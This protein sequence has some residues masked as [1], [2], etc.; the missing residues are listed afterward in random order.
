MSVLTED[1][2]KKNGFSEYDGGFYKQIGNICIRLVKNGEMYI[3]S[4][5][6]QDDKTIPCIK[7]Y[8]IEEFEE[9][10]KYVEHFLVFNL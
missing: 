6:T 2:L 9:F 8:E 7:I 5:V 1:Y 4:I 3:P 10:L